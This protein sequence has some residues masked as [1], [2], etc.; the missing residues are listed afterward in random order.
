MRTTIEARMQATIEE[1]AA[2]L[3][4]RQ[5]GIVTRRQLREAGFG[6]E[7]VDRRVAA[8]IFLS[9]H[10][11]VYLLGT[12]RDRLEPEWARVVAALVACGADA[13]VSH[14]SAGWLWRLLRRPNRAAPVSITVPEAARRQR[15]GILI[16]RSLDLSRAE[17]TRVEGIPV[18][19]PGRT[20]RD[21]STVLT[22]KDLNR[23][24]A[25]AERKGL[26]D[27]AGFPG[28]VA[29]H[30]GRPGAPVL[31]AALLGDGGPVLTRSEAEERVLTL[32]LE[33]GLPRPQVNVRVLGLEV[34]F[35]WPDQKLV[36]EADGFEHHRARGSFENDHQRDLEMEARGVTVLRVTWRQLV[37]DPKG[38]AGLISRSFGHAEARAARLPVR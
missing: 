5:H 13:V 14:G 20:L 35:Y 38:T 24:A 34:D 18:T 6:E 37:E 32:V 4:A 9:L 8:G 29:S 17:I 1:H 15:P 36:V 3:A 16:H 22:V 25:R 10:R 12:L 26:I 2:H 21:L 11:G 7:K 33:H 30:A 31:R 23:A 28:L 19:R 27:S